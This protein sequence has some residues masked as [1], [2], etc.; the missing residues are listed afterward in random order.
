MLEHLNFR[1]FFRPFSDSNTFER[2]APRPAR[3]VHHHPHLRRSRLRVP[4]FRRKVHLN[5]SEKVRKRLE[6]AEFELISRGDEVVFEILN[7]G[8]GFN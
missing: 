5:L 4:P 2:Q 1:S 6:N 7:F 3:V 8:E